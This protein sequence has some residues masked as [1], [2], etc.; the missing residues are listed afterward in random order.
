MKSHQTWYFDGPW[1]GAATVPGCLTVTAGQAWLTR[2]RDP[3]DHVLQA[4]ERLRL[5]R[6]D[7]ITAEPWQAGRTAGLAWQPDAPRQPGL[8]FLGWAGRGAALLARALAGPLLVLARKADA[9]A[10]R[11]QSCICAG[12]SIAS[13]G[14]AK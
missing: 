8:A 10:S 6:G 12:E 5:A 14:A 3:V 13:S 11:A 9:M 7:R 1:T 4:G 2:D